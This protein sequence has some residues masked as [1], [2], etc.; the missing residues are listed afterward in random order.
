M[1]RI[2]DWDSIIGYWDELDAAGR[3]REDRL[4][5]RYRALQRIKRTQE[6]IG[7]PAC[8]CCGE[9]RVEFLTVDHITAEA[10]DRDTKLV[11]G[12]RVKI[13]GDD[14]CREILRW[15]SDSGDLSSLRIAC[16]NCNCAAGRRSKIAS[17]DLPKC[18]YRL[19]QQD[20]RFGHSV[21]LNCSLVE[22]Q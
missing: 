20:G 12:K 10:R 2:M 7:W 9:Y 18:P 11:K 21:C 1:R 22:K 15:P 14:M 17:G 5:R 4:H 16:C 19:E 13:Y 3:R 6:P 8:Y